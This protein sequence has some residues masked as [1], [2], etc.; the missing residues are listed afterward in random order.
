MKSILAFYVDTAAA[1]HAVRA[2]NEAHVESDQIRVVGITGEERHRL[3]I[4]TR[5]GDLR[6]AFYGAIAGLVVG[7]LGAW[8]GQTSSLIDP[9]IGFIADTF[10]VTLLRFLVLGAG[11]GGLT[12]YIV[13]LAIWRI[14]ICAPGDLDQLEIRVRA[15]ER[16]LDQLRA[17]LER[18]GADRVEVS[19]SA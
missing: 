7:A 9:G 15:S 17:V 3:A 18:T 4:E 1:N 6:G 11:T 12:G 14:E 5:M 19:G 16:R 10:L 13:G 8:L 2:L